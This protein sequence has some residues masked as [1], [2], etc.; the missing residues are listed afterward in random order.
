MNINILL[1]LFFLLGMLTAGG[2]VLLIKLKNKYA[3]TVLGWIFTISGLLSLVFSIAWAIS[4]VIE[5]EN[6]A[7]GLGLLIFGGLSLVFFS[8]ATKLVK[9]KATTIQVE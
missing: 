4:S 8:I 2:I 5:Y 3:F 1:L 7:A 6:Q 9:K